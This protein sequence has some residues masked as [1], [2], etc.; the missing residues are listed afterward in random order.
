MHIRLPVE[1]ARAFERVDDHLRAQ[2]Q[3]IQL[4]ALELQQQYADHLCARTPA[5]T[6]PTRSNR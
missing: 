4:A 1:C 5:T 3:E 2:E 6:K